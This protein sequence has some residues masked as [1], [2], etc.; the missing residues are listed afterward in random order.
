MTTTQDTRT[1][2]VTPAA[3]KKY[4]FE[5]DPEKDFSD[6]GT[7]FTA[8]KFKD[9]LT[10]TYAYSY[11]YGHF[12]ALRLDYARLNHSNN[13][14]MYFPS[15]RLTNEFNGKEVLDLVKLKENAEHCLADLNSY[16]AGDPLLLS[17][18]AT[19][20]EKREKA[21]EAVDQARE[22]LDKAEKDLKEL[23]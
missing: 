4:G 15:Y 21:M 10:M 20:R 17:H 19:M 18:V 8:Y 23:A 7:R 2:R 16:K 11:D 22:A 5:R 9:G 6:D 14:D 3:F 13:D 12:A 1:S